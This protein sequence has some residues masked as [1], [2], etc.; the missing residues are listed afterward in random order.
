MGASFDN[1]AFM[2]HKDL[3]GVN[4]RVKAMPVSLVSAVSHYRTWSH[5]I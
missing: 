4:D 3:I 1:L 5:T 2:Y